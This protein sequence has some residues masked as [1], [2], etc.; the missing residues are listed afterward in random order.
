MFKF[1]IHT[2]YIG[3]HFVPMARSNSHRDMPIH[4]QYVTLPSLLP[5]NCG[6]GP[7][8]WNVLAKLRISNK[9]ICDTEAFLLLFQLKILA[10]SSLWLASHASLL[11]LAQKLVVGPTLNSVGFRVSCHPVIGW[12]MK[13]L[14]KW[15][16]P[17]P[18]CPDYSTKIMY[19]NTCQGITIAPRT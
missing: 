19:L 12:P 14:D 4:R 1:C 11:D 5:I 16:L 7:V 3:I 8:F 18:R 2:A 17:Q 13:S 9:N 15:G 6:V 10:K